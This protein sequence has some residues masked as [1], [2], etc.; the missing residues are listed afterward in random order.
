[1]IIHP[2][3]SRFST[4]R[5]PIK[6]TSGKIRMFWKSAVPPPILSSSMGLPNSANCV[7]T[8]FNLLQDEISGGRLSIRNMDGLD[9]QRLAL[10]EGSIAI[11]DATCTRSLALTKQ[12]PTTPQQQNPKLIPLPHSSYDRSPTQCDSL[13]VSTVHIS[14]LGSLSGWRPLP[15]DRSV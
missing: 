3:N 13:F 2:P 9:G 12:V 7:N 4:R 10:A 6:M 5:S 8:S 14:G 1:M 11:A 15:Y